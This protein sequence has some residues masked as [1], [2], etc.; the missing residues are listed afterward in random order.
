MVLNGPANSDAVQMVYMHINTEANAVKSLI[1]LK[2]V[3]KMLGMCRPTVMN[4][5]YD[6]K[7]DC[8]WFSP[9]LVYF[10]SEDINKFID[11]HSVHYNPKKL[12]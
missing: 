1:S 9:K 10:T 11:E 2:D 5:V 7:L 12:S 6:G 3:S 4:F 8:I